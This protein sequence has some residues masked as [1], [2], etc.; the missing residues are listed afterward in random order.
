MFPGRRTAFV[1]GA[2]GFV[3]RHLSERLSGG[4]W[5]VVALCRPTDR[6]DLL[7]SE[8]EV[9]LGD[10][11]DLARVL[12]AMPTAVDV[13]FHL[14]GNTSSRRCDRAAQWRDNVGGTTHVV[15]AAV[16]RSARRLVLTSS[17]SALGYQPGVP[18]DEKSVSNV[19][20]EGDHYGRT[21]R[22]AEE[23]VLDAWRERGLDAVVLNPANILGPY[24]TA[25]WSRQLIVPAAAGRLPFV[26][27]GS[28][29][30]LSVHDVVD[31]HVAAVDRAEPGSRFLLGGTRA[32]F[33]EIVNEVED[34]VGRRLS[35][36]LAPPWV[37]KVVLN[38]PR[39]RRA[40]GDL[41]VDDH[42]ARDVLGLRHTPIEEQ[43]ADTIAWLRSADMVA[44]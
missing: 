39:F 12:E 40:V 10:L 20:G 21:K 28:G 3:G 13:V 4:G 37:L 44:S 33:L 43:V 41:V 31:A 5:R 19:D 18:L 36:R 38:R 8:V 24:D 2:A 14:A 15:Q 17:T 42:R 22:V 25:N 16:T 1:T 32:S 9:I 35:T 27:P 29:S 26:P 11:A 30:W 7:P 23:L 34:Q 6:T